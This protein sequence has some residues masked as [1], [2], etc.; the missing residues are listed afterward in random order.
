M[1][2]TN[3][4]NS[5]WCT[6]K[7]WRSSIDSSRS[8]SVTLDVETAAADAEVAGSGQTA[9]LDWFHSSLKRLRG[10][11]SVGRNCFKYIRSHHREAPTFTRRRASTTYLAGKSTSQVCV[12]FSNGL[13]GI[14]NRSSS[15]AL[16]RTRT[17]RPSARPRSATEGQTVST[18][19]RATEEKV[20]RSRRRRRARRRRR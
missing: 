18:G 19:L 11:S 7:L 6:A 13:A 2:W 16:A 5:L 14:P 17:R 8:A 9:A 20:L 1:T 15:P 3:R 12:T 10:A 4:A